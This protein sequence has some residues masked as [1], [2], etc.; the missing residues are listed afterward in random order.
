MDFKKFFSELKRRNVYRVAIAYGISA[1][2][3][4]QIA[5]TVVPIINGPNW[6]T[7]LILI[8]L[9]I[10]FPIAMVMAWIYEISP[11]GMLKATEGINHED[12]QNLKKKPVIITL[13]FGILIMALLGQFMY[14]N[15]W[16][17][18]STGISISEKSIAV[19]PLE[20]LSADPT[21]QYLANGI[22][23]AITGHLSN[24]EGL[25][26]VPK[27]SVGQYR[28]TTKSAKTIGDELNVNY[29]IGGSFLMVD[30]KVT[31][32]VQLINTK[33]EDNIFYK[34]YNRDY[35]DIIKVQSEVAQSIANQIEV[36]ITPEIKKRIEAIPTES[37]EAY[38]Y[39]LK[40]LDYGSRS[41]QKNDHLYAIQMFGLSVKIDPKFTLAWLGLASKKRG[42]YWYNYDRTEK[43]LEQTKKALDSAISLDPDLMEVEMENAMYHYHCKLDYQKAL[44]ILLKLK[45]SHPNNDSLMANISFVYRRMGEYEKAM[46]YINHAILLNPN[47]YIYWWTAG[48]TSVIL[49]RY[50]QAEEYYKT[51]LDHNPSANSDVDLP[52]LYLITGE[53]DKAKKLFENSLTSD[54]PLIYLTHAKTELMSRNYNKAIGIL[55]SRTDKMADSHMSY[56]PKQLYLGQI[57]LAMSNHELSEKYFLEAQEILSAELN[58]YPQDSRIYS[59]LGIAYAGLGRKEIA[60]EMGSKALN[61]MSIPIDAWRG[62]SREL[63]MAK[64]LLMN[65][66]LTKTVIKLEFLIEQNGYLSVELLKNDPFWDP[67]RER[68]DFKSLIENPNYQV[69][70]TGS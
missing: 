38:D 53:I 59:S 51:A 49:K 64:I 33:D 36:I 14:H 48:E 44:E 6:L 11:E 1:W 29:L 35:N 18:K 54:I 63:D 17:I 16:N 26:V 55:E 68:N 56:T 45:S 42:M 65:G 43:N 5:A 8:V 22:G 7:K 3:L 15:Y 66:E 39:Y 46:E 70:K 32:I 50:P 40:G 58:N 9:A 20:Y 34:E 27:T 47:N 62:F 4:L 2:L 37:I 13:L 28:E 67:L 41:I 19:L 30:N 21:K 57:Y 60:K 31:L 61:I 23:D 52:G 12:H 10:G 24:I 69:T 25:R